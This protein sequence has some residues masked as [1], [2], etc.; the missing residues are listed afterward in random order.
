MALCHD[1][2]GFIP[3]GALRWPQHVCV[4]ETCGWPVWYMR[5]LYDILNIYIYIY[6]LMSNC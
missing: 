6:T 5:L 2:R 3:R 1:T 4:L